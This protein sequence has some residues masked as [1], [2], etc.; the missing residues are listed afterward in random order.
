MCFPHLHACE[1]QREHDGDSGDEAEPANKALALD[2]KL[3]VAHGYLGFGHL[4]ENDLPKAAREFELSFQ[5]SPDEP[6]VISNVSQMLAQLGRAD[7][8]VRAQRW[9][10]LRDPASAQSQFN[11]CNHLLG[12]DQLE[13]AESTC[14]TGLL[15]T[16]DYVYGHAV[17][18]Q[19]LL[20][21]GQFEASLKEA[22]AETDPGTKLVQAAKAL[23]ALGRRAESEKA[24]QHMI[25]NH[26]EGYDFGPAEVYA[27]RGDADKAFE[28]LERARLADDP[29]I[30]NTH[31]STAL[32]NLHKDPRWIPFLRKIGR[33]PE[34]LA[35]IK[36]NPKLPD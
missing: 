25:K 22:N 27:H 1:Y 19:V 13:D 30:S 29:E 2:P 9:L 36:F 15:L 26:S 24:L 7:E 34:Q 33:A 14:R 28:W 32:A 12:A 17:L 6:R 21:R 3:G 10:V 11:F 8:A 31:V 5:I 23:D 16:P 20:Q 35:K 18:A 4:L